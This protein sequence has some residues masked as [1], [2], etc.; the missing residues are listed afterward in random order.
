MMSRPIISTKQQKTQSLRPS[1]TENLRHEKIFN[2]LHAELIVTTLEVR[3]I[4]F[5]LKINMN[6][7]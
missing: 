3:L 5:G 4:N 1:Q 6:E 2:P 7:H